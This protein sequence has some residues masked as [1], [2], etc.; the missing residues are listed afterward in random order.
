MSNWNVVQKELSILNET[1]DQIDIMI[2][3]TKNELSQTPVVITV[4]D[5]STLEIGLLTDQMASV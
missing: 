1:L 3:N 4:A 2:D 5:L